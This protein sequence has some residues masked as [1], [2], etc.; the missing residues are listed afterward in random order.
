VLNLF[1][2]RS[3]W[4]L[5]GNVTGAQSALANL[6]VLLDSDVIAASRG[7]EGAF[8]LAELYRRTAQEAITSRAIGDWRQGRGVRLTSSPLPFSR[9]ADLHK[10]TVKAVMVV[11]RASP[12]AI[13]NS[14]P[15]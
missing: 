8:L 1:S 5:L 6:R 12:G 14:R 4:I 10:S 3:R 11:S 2:D 15:A 7:S 13:A 9:R